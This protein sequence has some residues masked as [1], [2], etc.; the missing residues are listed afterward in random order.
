MTC[1]GCGTD[2][3]TG[4]RFCGR[5]GS[6]A[7]AIAAASG[8]SPGLRALAVLAA[9]IV[10]LALGLV[11]ALVL[12]LLRPSLFF[13]LL[14]LGGTVMMALSV[15]VMLRTARKAKAIVPSGLLVSMT[16]SL[17]SVIVYAAVLGLHLRASVWFAA[18]S[19]GTLIGTGWS[20][21]ARLRL[22]RGTVKREGG[23][24]YLAVWGF[25]FALSQLLV[26]A[27]GRAPA[28]AM[29]P[30]LLGTG[31][32]VGQST[33]LLWSC[34]RLRKGARGIA[35]VFLGLSLLFPG[36]AQ[37]G[38]EAEQAGPAR[39]PGERIVATLKDAA[40]TLGWSDGLITET[41][42]GWL[43]EPPDVKLNRLSV[44]TRGCPPPACQPQQVDVFL[45]RSVS[46]FKVPLRPDMRGQCSGNQRL[47][48]ID[49]MPGCLWSKGAPD[50][51]FWGFQHEG[52]TVLGFNAYSTHCYAGMDLILAGVCDPSQDNVLPVAEAVH[53]AALRN[54]LY[55]ALLPHPTEPPPIAVPEEQAPPPQPEEPAPTT[56]PR[57]PAIAQGPRRPT[58]VAPAG[59]A[60]GAVPVS[61]EQPQDP[62][63]DLPTPAETAAASVASGLLM[64][65]GAWLFGKANG[66]GLGEVAGEVAVPFEEPAHRDGEV[67][68]DTG[69]VWSAEDGGWVSENLYQQE[70]QRRG[71][72]PRK[73]VEDLASASRPGSNEGDLARQISQADRRIETRRQAIQ[74]RQAE[75][76]REEKEVQETEE[77]LGLDPEGQA[78][79]D[80]FLEHQGKV[81]EQGYRIVNPGYDASLPVREVV[82][83][84]VL[85]TRLTGAAGVAVPDFKPVRCGE[86]ADLGIAGARKYV[87]ELYGDQADRVIVDKVWVDVVRDDSLGGQMNAFVD[88]WLAPKNH[89]ATRVILPD[90]R[91]FV[92]DYWEANRGSALQMVSEEQWVARWR[93]RLGEDTRYMGSSVN[94][95]IEGKLDS[96]VE[97]YQKTKGGTQEQALA[98]FRRFETDKIRAGAGSVQEKERRLKEL[99][100]LIRSYQRCGRLRDPGDLKFL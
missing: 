9:S 92:L 14:S 94:D 65:V 81:L 89:V 59:E 100:T 8:S 35:G 28:L 26:A 95:A 12:W 99:E 21:T 57:E 7:R 19:C 46:V 91:R 72:L 71:W 70:Q 97:A 1:A 58:R 79:Q 22:E 36:L 60:E 37:A 96:Q 75:I 50:Q 10:A 27:T 73:A 47:V 38:A 90:G 6:S 18:L 25:V 86:L 78:L 85:V 48:D 87:R 98:T 4:A 62:D 44:P 53:Q 54:G 17:L 68:A 23:W 80:K 32:V 51:I 40:R 43:L 64:G 34:R 66:V 67:K 63:A 11:I 5:C 24:L 74:E 93:S 55:A 83:A 20:L 39:L 31:I 33:T 30:L 69:E 84:S 42:D 52:R 88:K 49:G 16:V 15:L 29:L 61:P 2:L 3:E 82:D 13:R 77:S 76:D 45:H 56:A 41:A